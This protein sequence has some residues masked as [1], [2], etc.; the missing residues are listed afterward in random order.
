[1]RLKT[2][3]IDEMWAPVYNV[4]PSQGAPA[5]F[6]FMAAGL[7]AIRL[8]ISVRP[9]GGLRT[10]IENLPSIAP[11]VENELTFWGVPADA[12]HDADRGRMLHVLLRRP[13]LRRQRRL[14]QQ[15]PAQTVHVERDRLRPA[16]AGAPAGRRATAALSRP[17]NARAAGPRR[18]R[19]A[20][21]RRDRHGPRRHTVAGA[22]SG[23][24]VELKVPQ[25]TD[26][27]Q[28]ATPQLKQAVV[29]L[30]LGTVISPSVSDGLQTCAEERFGFGSDAPASCPAESKIGDVAIDS[31]LLSTPLTGAVFLA[32][33][34]PSAAAAAGA[35]RR[36]AGVRLKLPGR[37]DADPV[38]GQLTATFDQNPQLPFRSLSMTL[39]GGPRAVLANPRQCGP[40]RSTAAL[41]PYGGGPAVEAADSFEVSGDGAERPALR[42]TF[43]P[44]LSAG[45]ASTAAGAAGLFTLTFAGD[46][47]DD[48]LKAVDVSLPAGVMPKIASVAALCTEAQ[49]AAGGCDEAS[50]IGTASVLAGPGAAAVPA[51][52]AAST[53]AAPTEARR[54]AS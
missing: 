5:E 10:T 46:D 30:P 19:R 44:A 13:Q 12:S 9:D 26:P 52:S 50:R 45:S 16:A 23:Y 34:T 29:R 25:S 27:D 32:A 39:K 8:Q 35:R 1:M 41:T 49:A 36:G 53:S 4:V 14:P 37:I 22:P 48:L 3:L 43:T 51:A 15:R 6:G 17:T 33:Q 18:L 21:I 54:T 7:L 40:A 28:L 47:A 11:L 20:Q 2:G 24:R 42:A 38:T 31:L